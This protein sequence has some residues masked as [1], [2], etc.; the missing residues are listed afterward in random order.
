V[1]IARLTSNLAIDNPRSLAF[2]GARVTLA[3]G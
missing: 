3:D 2:G 1:G